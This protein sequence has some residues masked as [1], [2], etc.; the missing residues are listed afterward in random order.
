MKKRR[1]LLEL[2]FEEAL[3]DIAKRE[4]VTVDVLRAA[5]EAKYPDAGKSRAIRAYVMAYYQTL[6]KEVADDGSDLIVLEH[7]PGEMAD[8]DHSV[9]VMRY[10][11][12][13]LRIRV[14]DRRASGGFGHHGGIV[15]EL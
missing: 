5:I 8:P 2:E 11:G 4:R 13:Q 3:D 12:G 10:L 6:A 1:R 14:S 15:A 7:I 9:I